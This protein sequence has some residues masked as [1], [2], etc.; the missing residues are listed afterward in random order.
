MP[1]PS[2]RRFGWMHQTT[3]P[4]HERRRSERGEG[5]GKGEAAWT[6]RAAE[7]RQATINLIARWLLP[8]D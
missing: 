3:R 2:D 4:E 1:D 8:P 6:D 5:E 7:A